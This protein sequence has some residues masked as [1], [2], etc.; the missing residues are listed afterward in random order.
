[1]AG[2]FWLCGRRVRA[3]DPVRKPW[4]LTG[5][6]PPAATRTMEQTQSTD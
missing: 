3:C 1:L 5:E 6:R 4:R 2:F